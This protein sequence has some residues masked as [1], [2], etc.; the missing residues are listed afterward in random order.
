MKYPEC[1]II[2]NKK[3]KLSSLLQFPNSDNVSHLMALNE[4]FVF[5]S[6]QILKSNLKS[7]EII[8]N[9]GDRTLK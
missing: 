3:H 1:T 5:L 2:I 9:L 7:G 6:C 4:C 8:K